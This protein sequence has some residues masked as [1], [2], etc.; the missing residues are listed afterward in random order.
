M[1]CFSSK[2]RIEE[3]CQGRASDGTGSKPTAKCGK[4]PSAAVNADSKRDLDSMK[5]IGGIMEAK[6]GC[7]RWM[8]GVPNCR[9]EVVLQNFG[10]IQTSWAGF[11]QRASAAQAYIHNPELETYVLKKRKWKRGL[12]RFTDTKQT[13]A[14]ERRS[15]PGRRRSAGEPSSPPCLSSDGSHRPPPTQ[16]APCRASSHQPW[17]RSA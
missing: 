4:F 7:Q 17:Q 13:I 12:L 9:E 1:C 15:R 2:S 6:E 8:H 11:F 3:I 16:A 10:L 14:E 5:A